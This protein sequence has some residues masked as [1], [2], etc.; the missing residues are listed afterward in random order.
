MNPCFSRAGVVLILVSLS[1]IRLNAQTSRGTV[2]GVV[3]DTSK[4]SVPGAAVEITQKETNVTRST[5]TN[6]DGVYRFDAVEL[7]TYDVIVKGQGFKT[8]TSRDVP[9]AAAQTVGVDAQ[10]EV[11]DNVSV[12]EVN[13]DAIALQTEAPVRGGN[14]NIVQATQ[15]PIFGRNP[16]LLAITL[17]GVTEQRSNLPGIAT[18]SVN[19]GRGRS[20]NFLL[21]GTENN[22]ISVAGQAFQVKIPDAVQEVSVQTANYDAEFGRA[23]GAVV[24]TITKSGTNEIHGTLGWVADFTNDDAIT[25]T[26]S[27]SDA[28]RAR[29][30]LPAGYEQYYNGTIGG[31][32]K[33]DRTFFFTSWQEQRRRASV[34]SPFTVPT[35]AGRDA[36]RRVFPQGA[37]PRVDLYL[38]VT[39]SVIA[40][41]QPTA[42]DLG[43]GRGN[44]ELGTAVVSIPQQLDGRQSLSKVDHHFSEKDILSVRYGFDRTLDPVEG[45]NFPGFTTSEVQ[46]YHNVVVTETHIFS[47]TLTNELRVPFNRMEFEFPNDATDPRAA[48]MPEYVFTG[49]STI[50]VSRAFPQGRTSNNYIIQD[51]MSYV[52]GKHTFRFGLDLLQQRSRQIAPSAMRGVVTY[53]TSNIAGQAFHSFVNFIDDFGATGSVT[54]D[55]GSATYYPELFRQA[56]F[57][58]DR[59]QVRDNLTVTLG[60]R[61]EDFGTPANSLPTPAFAGLFN[62]VIDRANREFRAPMTEPNR[63]ERDL[64][65]FAPVVG[66]TWSPRFSEGLLGRILGNRRSVVRAGFNMGYDSFFNNIASNAATSAPNLVATSLASVTSENPRGLANFSSLVPQT[67]RRVLPADR[68]DLVVQSLRNPYYARWSFGIQREMPWGLLLD[69][70]YVGSSGVRLYASEDLNP[71]VLNPALRVLPAGFS[72]LT[73][74]PSALPAGYSLQP[75]IDPLQ[76]VRIIRTNGGHSSYHSAQFQLQKRFTRDL[77][78]NMAYTWSKL[79]DNN[80]EVFQYNNTTPLAA[81]P[82]PFGGQHLEKALSLY[83]RPYRLVLSYTWQVPMFQSQKGLA[84]HLLGGWRVAGITTLESGV[85]L[86]VVNG[87]DADGLG[88]ALD[89]P[90][91]NPAGRAGVRARPSSA[92]STGYVNPDVFGSNGQ[93]VPIDPSEARYIGLPECTVANLATCRTGTAGRN[94]ARTPGLRNNNVNVFKNVRLTE[95]LNLEFRTEFYNVL[96]TP[97]YGQ[98]GVSPFTPQTS[99][100]VTPASNVTGSLAG[101]FLQYQFLEGGGRVIRYQL[102]LRF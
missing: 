65:N 46:R 71:A 49:V 15:L 17:P 87:V 94:L 69:S 66:V 9:V 51:T 98:F 4:A 18:F 58:Q 14:I 28:I 24:N 38:D 67:P 33:R 12:V 31:P 2:T 96:N 63:T 53:G 50:G 47:P 43:L 26:L 83:D 32:I 52:R 41:G 102:T 77:G 29:G 5:T 93:P 44:V 78:F 13:A 86:N 99:T 20:N 40:S 95:R 76:G 101:R 68:Q 16:N 75:N 62:V 21:D 45:I 27:T 59:W 61:W 3:I 91:L 74:L 11:G 70:S 42:I 89:R 48:T 54:R 36:L 19:G 7:G 1:V 79:L 60:L 73:E 90:D 80:S 23:G 92:S 84:G 8:Y 34:N 6:Q 64:N 55:F 25:N 82:T 81:I 72:S 39:K 10:L 30:K 35:Q 22:D 100:S 56:Y 37:N 88:G 57:L 97:Q 85:P